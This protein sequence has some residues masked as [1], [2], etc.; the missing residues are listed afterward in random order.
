MPSVSAFASELIAQL[1]DFAILICSMSLHCSES[2]F[3]F[4][5]SFNSV[6]SILF[7]V[8]ILNTLLANR[9][10]SIE[11]NRRNIK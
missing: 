6:M 5:N 3:Q 10:Y 1:F 11:I 2:G 4:G 9:N 7:P 8:A